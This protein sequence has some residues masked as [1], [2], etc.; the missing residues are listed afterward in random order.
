MRKRIMTG[1]LKNGVKFRLAELGYSDLEPIMQLQEKAVD[2]MVSPHF[3]QPLST[4]EVAWI[5]SG[6]GRIIGAYVQNRLAA[7]RALLVPK[8][9]EEYLG[10]DGGI[11]N[12]ERSRIIYSEISV[13]DPDYRGNRLQN[14]MGRILL[15]TVDRNRFRYILA[16]VAPFNIASIKDKFELGMEIAALKK[17]YGGKWRYIFMKDMDHLSR[18]LPCRDEKL[19]RM[20]EIHTQQELLESGYRGKG[21]ERIDGQWHVRFCEY[22]EVLNS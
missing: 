5:L 22:D 1:L 7:F 20:D 4:E 2:H 10:K 14:K 19:I 6:H 18:S 15:K 21:L 17:K 3:L 16:T 11:D 12:G 9:S 8:L 13:V